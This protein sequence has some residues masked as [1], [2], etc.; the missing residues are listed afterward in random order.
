MVFIE[1]G[2]RV[3]K[4][5]D[6]EELHQPMLRFLIIVNAFTKG[7]DTTSAYYKSNNYV[8]EL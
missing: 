5:G 6:F 7:K 2:V 8:N 1:V 4:C 3:E